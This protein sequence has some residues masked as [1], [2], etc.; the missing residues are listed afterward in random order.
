MRQFWPF[1]DKKGVYILI[2]D[3]LLLFSPLKY[4]TTNEEYEKKKNSCFGFFV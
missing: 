3:V 2:Q 1:V 4:N